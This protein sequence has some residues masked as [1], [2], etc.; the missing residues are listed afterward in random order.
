LSLQGEADFHALDVVSD[1]VYGYDATSARLMTTTARESWT[2]IADGELVDIAVV[3]SRPDCIV[4]TTPSGAVR[5]VHLNGSSRPLGTAPGLVWIVSDPD[6]RL[7]GI[8]AD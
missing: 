4:V 7:V 5:Q 1:R 3:P 6:G 2:T 8:T